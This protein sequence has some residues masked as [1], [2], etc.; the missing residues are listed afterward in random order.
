[1]ESQKVD[2]RPSE[3]WECNQ[4]KPRELPWVLPC[5]GAMGFHPTG[6]TDAGSQESFPRYFF[7][8]LRGCGFPSYRTYRCR[9]AQRT[10]GPATRMAVLLACMLVASGLSVENSDLWLWV[11]CEP[12]SE[13]VGH[14]PD[15]LLK[16]SM[17]VHVCRWKPRPFLMGTVPVALPLSTGL[18]HLSLLLG[19]DKGQGSFT[20]NAAPV[21]SSTSESRFRMC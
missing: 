7:P 2:P 1:M 9:K 14:F 20:F 21:P 19:R 11:S 16:V 8:Y 3:S 13:H 6:L 10:L 5:H 17:A 15:G 4:A 18:T 12:C